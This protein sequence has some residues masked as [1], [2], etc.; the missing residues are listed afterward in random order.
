MEKYSNTGEIVDVEGNG[1]GWTLFE[2]SIVGEERETPYLG[3]KLF[4]VS[5]EEVGVFF[6][7]DFNG[8]LFKDYVAALVV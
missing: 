7:E 3:T 1:A 2:N 4:A 8:C 6:G 5:F